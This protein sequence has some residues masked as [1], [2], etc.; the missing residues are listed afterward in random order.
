MIRSTRFVFVF[1]N[2]TLFLM[3]ANLFA[4]LYFYKKNATVHCSGH[5]ATLT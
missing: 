5:V 4:V 2:G 1:K 3:T